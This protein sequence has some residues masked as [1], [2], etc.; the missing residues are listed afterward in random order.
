MRYSSD[1]CSTALCI[2]LRCVATPLSLSMPYY[3]Q[4]CSFF[5]LNVCICADLFNRLNSYQRFVEQ[6]KQTTTTCEWQMLQCH[7]I[8][9]LFLFY[10]MHLSCKNRMRSERVVG[11]KLQRIQL[12]HASRTNIWRW[13]TRKCRACSPHAMTIR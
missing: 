8:H 10:N 13:Q 5:A 1:G 12:D 6:H 4:F 9:L 2:Y 7:L 3:S 11:M